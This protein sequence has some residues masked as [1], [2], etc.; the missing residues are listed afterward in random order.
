MFKFIQPHEIN[1]FS[2]YLVII[3]PQ[4][5]IRIG[6]WNSNS[7]TIFMQKIA[8]VIILTRN[9]KPYSPLTIRGKHKTQETSK[10]RKLKRHQD[11]WNVIKI[12]YLKQLVLIRYKY[13]RF[14]VVSSF[15]FQIDTT[16]IVIFLFFNNRLRKVKSTL[17][18]KYQ[19]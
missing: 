15:F 2:F 8:T 14:R 19:Q 13:R 17:T 5:A 4:T 10:C 9:H 11:I 1:I 12:I 6:R 16:Y 7:M 18:Q 3:A